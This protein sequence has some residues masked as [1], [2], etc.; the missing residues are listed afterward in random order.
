M[1]KKIRLIIGVLVFVSILLIASIMVLSDRDKAINESTSINNEDE[2]NGGSVEVSDLE[3]DVDMI[4][5]G[6]ILI[7]NSEGEELDEAHAV[8]IYENAKDMLHKL[9]FVEAETY[10]Y[11]NIK[12]YNLNL[13]DNYNKYLKDRHLD[14]PIMTYLSEAEEYNNVNMIRDLLV[15]IKDTENYF[16]GIMSLTAKTRIGLIPMP[17]SINPSFSGDIKIN[18]V[19]EVDYK[20]IKEL[21]TIDGRIDNIIKV[22]EID[23]TV[24]QCD[25][26]AYIV[27]NDMQH[28][29]YTMLEKEKGA[30]HF[31]TNDEW[32]EIL[33]TGGNLSEKGEYNK[34]EGDENDR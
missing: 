26:L 31:I 24:Q 9:E 22:T 19:N 34:P 5:S 2:I 6:E 3:K 27:T 29:L 21:S 32:R 28:T 18:S 8:M 23:Y 16:L 14:I 7:G 17:N 30:T 1:N 25:L 13:N 12:D 15:E 4:S 11:E 33:G 10:I 20:N